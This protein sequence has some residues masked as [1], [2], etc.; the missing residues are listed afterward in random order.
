MSQG[1]AFHIPFTALMFLD[2]LSLDPYYFRSVSLSFIGPAFESFAHRSFLFPFVIS[3]SICR[4]CAIYD[5]VTYSFSDLLC[6][7][8]LYMCPHLTKPILRSPDVPGYLNLSLFFCSQ[9]PLCIC[10][11][12]YYFPFTFLLAGR[13]SSFISLGLCRFLGSIAVTYLSYL[14]LCRLVA[15]HSP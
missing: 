4:F 3:K 12:L 1:C 2:H 5:I 7:L 6:A 9:K 11:G 13:F 14:A 8:F 10:C 15:L